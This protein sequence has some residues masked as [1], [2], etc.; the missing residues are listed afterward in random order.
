LLGTLGTIGG[1]AAGFQ[2]G[3]AISRGEEHKQAK[4]NLR[5]FEHVIDLYGEIP[6]L[7]RD[8]VRTHPSELVRK[9]TAQLAEQ[10]IVALSAHRFHALGN[11]RLL[12][13]IDRA[14]QGFRSLQR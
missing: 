5:K 6:K 1:S 9:S 11:P 10:Q 8:R 14:I 4:V 12:T 7:L 3:R 13:K 2:A